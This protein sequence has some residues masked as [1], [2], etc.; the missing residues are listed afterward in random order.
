MYDY[1]SADWNQ[2]KLILDSRVDLDFSLDRIDN[3]SQI[4]TMVDTFTAA[5]LEARTAAVLMVRPFR[6]SLT[7]TPEIKSLIFERCWTL[8]KNHQK[9][10]KFQSG[11]VEKSKFRDSISPLIRANL[12]ADRI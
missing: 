6:F 12:T 4:D 8:K 10:W 5:I 2:F 11:Q 1:K 3:E 7:L 9:P